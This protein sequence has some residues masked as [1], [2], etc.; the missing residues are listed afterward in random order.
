MA[1]DDVAIAFAKRIPCDEENKDDEISEEVKAVQ[2]P[3][4]VQSNTLPRQPCRLQR[5]PN[6]LYACIHQMATI[7]FSTVD[8]QQRR[9]FIGSIYVGKVDATSTCASNLN[10][11]RLFISNGF[12]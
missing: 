3:L 6:I 1:Q 11:F 4:V 9:T 2:S 5:I 10:I 8:K 12:Q 7:S